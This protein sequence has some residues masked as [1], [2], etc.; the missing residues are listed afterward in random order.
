MLRELATDRAFIVCLS[1]AI[2]CFQAWWRLRRAG[3]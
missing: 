3:Q 1:A 2:W